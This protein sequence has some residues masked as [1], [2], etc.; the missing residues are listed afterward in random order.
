MNRTRARTLAR[1]LALAASL[2]LALTACAPVLGGLGRGAEATAFVTLPSGARCAYAGDGA[3]LAFDG[4]R[5]AWTCDALAG[6]PTGLLGAPQVG[7]D[8][9]TLRWR[10]GVLGT[11]PEGGFALAEDTGLLGRAYVLE[12][13]DG[14][15]CAFA[16][17]GAT[18]AV[19]GRRVDY[20]C[21]GDVV[22]LGPLETDA[23]GVLATR[24]SVVR[25]ADGFEVV[26][27]ARVRV[28]SVSL[29]EPIVG[30]P[31]GTT[32]ALE[33]IMRADGSLA[34]P[35]EPERYTLTLLEDGSAIVRADCNQGVGRYVLEGARLDLAPFATTKMLC[36]AGSLDVA[37]LVHLNAT[38]RYRLEG[39][40]L[41]LEADGGGALWF[42]PARP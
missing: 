26:G 40:R 39:E 31:V 38:V 11:A 15:R 19:D 20:T 41:V 1:T 6:A 2:A 18:L 12:L 10:F 30:G 16:G 25:G 14:A 3:T 35:A 23:R 37:F 33:R 9:S 5:L 21:G 28:A 22:V 29:V 34:V 42:T 24:A 36:A 17:E 7:E 4:D 27:A 13:A 8:G 32:W